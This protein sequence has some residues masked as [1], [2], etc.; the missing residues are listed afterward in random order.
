[1]AQERDVLFDLVKCI[2][3]F[4]VIYGH[5]TGYRSGFDLS[6]MPSNAANFII[7]VNMPL[8]FMVSGY[9]SRRLHESKNWRKLAKRL[10]GYFWPL[11]SIGIIFAVL[12]SF[13]WGKF[14]ISSIPM[15]VVRRFLFGGWFFYALAFCDVATFLAFYYGKVAKGMT[16]ICTVFF[17]IALLG[18]GRVWHA[19]NIVAMIP[20]YW[21]GLWVLPRIY[22]K[23]YELPLS[24]I[25]GGVM[26]F[27]T[28]FSGNIATNGL[29]FYWNRFDV[30]HPDVRDVLLM[31]ARYIVGVL[32]SLFVLKSVTLIVKFVPK[33]T[34]FSFL[35]TETLG[36]YFLQGNIIHNLTNRFVPLD[37]SIGLILIASVLVYALSFLVVRASKWNQQV[38]FAIWGKHG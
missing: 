36:V 25:G 10:T 5:V 12:D 27:V 1:M 26:L 31:L 7:A 13:V 34:I 21:F 23:R 4:M 17:V 18:S 28:F 37:A 19:Q 14:P 16:A 32:G 33:I 11:A 6:T 20:V 22:N 9:F 15:T 38:A 29:S 8:F 3:M 2:A 24:I 30:I 35:G